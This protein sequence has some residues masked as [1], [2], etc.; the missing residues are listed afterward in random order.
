MKGSRENELV[1]A[2]VIGVPMTSAN[3]ACAKKLR[4]TRRKERVMKCWLR[5]LKAEQTYPLGEA[6]G[7]HRREKQL[8]E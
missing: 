4:R 6:L 5:L 8:N 3:V 1:C 2:E 7:Q